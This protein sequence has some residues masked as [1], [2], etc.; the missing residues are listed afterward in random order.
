MVGRL[1][2]IWSSGGSMDPLPIAEKALP[3]VAKNRLV[4]FD[5]LQWGVLPGLVQRAILWDTGI[6]MT[7]SSDYV[8]ILTVCGQTMADLMLDVAVVQD[9]VSNSSTCVLSKCGGNAQFLESCLTDVI[10]PSVRCFVDKTT[11]G[12]VPSFSGVYWAA[13]GGNEEAPAPVLRDHT[14]LNTSVNKLYA[15]HLVDKVFSG[16]RSGEN[17]HSLWRRK[18]K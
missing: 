12:T 11:L 13:D 4:Q 18:P 14:S 5:S 1:Y 10:V 6:V 16:V 7:S 8:Q 3:Q 17:D 2:K 9:I 15:I